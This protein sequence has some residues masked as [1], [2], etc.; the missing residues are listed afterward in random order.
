MDLG[1]KELGSKPS[2]VLS[3]ALARRLL[4]KGKSAEA[5]DKLLTYKVIGNISPRISRCTLKQPES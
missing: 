1:L 4:D 5:S 2:L 3:L